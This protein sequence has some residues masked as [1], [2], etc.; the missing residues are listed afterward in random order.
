MNIRGCGGVVA[1]RPMGGRAPSL[2]GESE[3][4]GLGSENVWF[5]GCCDASDVI[6]G[7]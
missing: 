6:D 1:Q 3:K 2:V 5:L 7:E 4:K